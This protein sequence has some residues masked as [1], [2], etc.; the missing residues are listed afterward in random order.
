M[1]KKRDS[2]A[3]LMPL[4]RLGSQIV[5][6]AASLNRFVW[7]LARE[8]EPRGDL[9]AK[10][11][12]SDRRIHLLFPPGPAEIRTRSSTRRRRH[13]STVP[14]RRELRPSQRLAG[15]PAAARQTMDHRKEAEGND[16]AN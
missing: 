1:N 12:Y 8:Q 2:C 10:Q 6:L 13:E 9:A 4:P 7:P 15:R 16:A 11:P 14:W 5:I 3:S